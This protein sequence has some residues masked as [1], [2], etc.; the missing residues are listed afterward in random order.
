MNEAHLAQSA[1]SRKVY[2]LII[3][4]HQRSPEPPY[5]AQEVETGTGIT[6]GSPPRCL[7]QVIA[8]RKK[9]ENRSIHLLWGWQLIFTKAEIWAASAAGFLYWSGPIDWAHTHRPPFPLP[10]P[11]RK[12][13]S[14]HRERLGL[15][16]WEGL[17]PW[18]EVVMVTTNYSEWTNLFDVLQKGI[19]GCDWTSLSARGKAWMFWGGN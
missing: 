7:C 18:K 17:F 15:Y 14:A 1:S 9:K 2:G 11:V 8:G 13:I 4:R 12:F 19:R 5:P 10:A 16:G 3:S 6:H